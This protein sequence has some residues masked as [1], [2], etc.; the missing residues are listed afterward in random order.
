MNPELEPLLLA[1]DAWLQAGPD[2]VERRQAVFESHLED[3]L[4]SHPNLTREKFM[5]ALRAYYVRWLRAQQHP[6]TMPPRA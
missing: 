1:Y 3:T 5:V 4:A 2:D 6:P